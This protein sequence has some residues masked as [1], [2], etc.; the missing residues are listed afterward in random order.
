MVKERNREIEAIIEK[1]GDETH[2]TQKQLMQQYE[3]KVTEL[4][5]KAAREL[6]EERVKTETA[7]KKLKKEQD[8]RLLLDENMKI[9]SRRV[10]DLESELTRSKELLKRAEDQVRDRSVELQKVEDKQEETRRE[11]IAEMKERLD[12][13]EREIRSL[14]TQLQEAQHLAQLE[15]EKVR[16]ENKNDLEL[17]QEKV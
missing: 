14:T 8:E 5:K 15:L 7:Y 1:L 16:N 6:A 2:D 10:S 12:A 13:K 9:L 17:I 3:A 11:V 4:D